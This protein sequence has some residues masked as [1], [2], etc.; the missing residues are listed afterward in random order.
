VYSYG[1]SSTYPTSTYNSA[2]YWVDVLYAIATTYTAGGKVTGAPAGTALTLTGSSTATTGIDASGNYTFNNLSSGTYTITPS[3]SGVTFTPANQTVTINGAHALGIDF[4]GSTT[5]FTVSGTITGAPN[6]SVVLSGANT[7]NTVTDASGN[8]TFTG[9]VNGSYTVTPGTAGF[10]VTPANQPVTVNGAN[11]TGVNFTAT[12][13]SFNIGGTISGG[14]G[15]TVTLSGGASATT[16]ADSSGNYSFAGYPIGSYTVTPAQTGKVFTPV[17]ITIAV[18]GAN[19][20]ANFTVPSACPCDTIW[21]PSATPALVDAG[22]THA[23]EYGVKIRADQDG[24]ITGIRF[25]K[26]VANA[27]AHTGDLW[28]GTGSNLGTASFSSETASGWQQVLF[29]HPVPVVKNTTYVASYFTPTGH[30]AADS[31]YFASSG[32][33]V[34]PLHALANG[35]DGSNGV[36]GYGTSTLFPTSSFNAANYWVDAV[37]LPTTTYTIA[38]I[39][40]GTG[41]AGATVTMSGGS[42]AT[43]T[44]DSSGNFSFNGLA[45]G[46]YT[47]TPS[48]SGA[49]F[50]PASQPV[51]INNGHALGLAFT[52]TG[53]TYSLSGTIS[54]T[55]G[56]GATVN[57]TGASTASVT[58]N[59][60]GVY[61]FTGLANGSYT[62]T[63]TKSGFLMTPVSRAVTINGANATANFSSAQTFTLSGT[64]SGSGG[65]GATVK[66]TG[67][68]TATVTANTSGQFTFTGLPNGTYTVTPSKLLHI[69]SPS[70]QTVTISGAN[71]T[72]VNFSTLL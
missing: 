33:D 39:L 25:Y 12:T 59:T 3:S 54:G 48:A 6:D 60:S 67:T 27:G 65:S 37:Y 4:V 44:A 11:V 35:V 40:S 62:V 57:L 56:S 53:A 9:V 21:Q 5:S 68:T 72:G 63:P 23:G 26:S 45:N 71:K 29:A 52:G 15:A 47:V 22:D 61:S 69:Y 66:L 51:T 16:T 10:T 28:S 42:S 30:Y 8:Y 46:T 43:V 64:I 1:A 41:A 49:S 2:N 31:G 50:S 24:Y 34:A 19:I 17:S 32:V 70:K 7:Y 36:Y 14:A 18:Q 55:G 20:T 13:Q 58:A 38:G